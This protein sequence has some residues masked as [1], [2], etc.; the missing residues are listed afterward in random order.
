M[1]LKG[2]EDEGAVPSA[3]HVSSWVQ[4]C[5]YHRLT[6]KLRASLTTSVTPVASLIVSDT[7]VELADMY[8]AEDPTPT[9]H[10]EAHQPRRRRQGVIVRS[11]VSCLSRSIRGS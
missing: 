9:R 2:G 8:M 10:K 7:P 1:R 5:A 3:P 11:Q 4:V 6:V